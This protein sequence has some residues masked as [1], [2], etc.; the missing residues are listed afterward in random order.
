[1]SINKCRM[2]VMM[3]VIMWML[4]TRGSLQINTY[5]KKKIEC[6]LKAIR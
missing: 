6:E 1:M 4:L 3:I 5:L 2:M